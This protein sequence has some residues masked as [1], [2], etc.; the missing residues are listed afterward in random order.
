M[1]FTE[2]RSWSNDYLTNYGEVLGAQKIE[3]LTNIHIDYTCV[4]ETAAVEKYG[5]LLASGEYPDMSL[6]GTYPGGMD[7]GVSDGVLRI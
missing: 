7:A 4:P 6:Y 5:L 1:T 2:W 3:E